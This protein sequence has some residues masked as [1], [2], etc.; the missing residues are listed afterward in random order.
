MKGYDGSGGGPGGGVADGGEEIQQ[1]GGLGAPCAAAALL[2]I[3]EV[4][5]KSR[6][7]PAEGRLGSRLRQ[8]Q[9]W[10]GEN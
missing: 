1:E 9:G 5:Q 10:D 2:G 4:A 6:V 3:P 8:R 7:D